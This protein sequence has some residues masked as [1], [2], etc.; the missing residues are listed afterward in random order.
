MPARDPTTGRFM[1]GGG[2]NVG[3]LKV[4]LLGDA[5]SYMTMMQRAEMQA[6]RTAAKLRRL[7]G[8]MEAAGKK[9]IK[10]VT[11]PAAI[12]GGLSVRAFAKF[13]Q[14][15]TESTSIMKVTEKQTKQMRDTALS[16][17]KEA[18]QGPAELARS[19]FYLAS[20]GKNAEQSMALL[21]AMTKFATAGAFDMARATDLL[22]DAQS[23]L[24][25]SSKNAVQDAKNMARVSDV[26]VGANTLANASVEQFAISLTS[27][28]G[29]AFKSYNIQL[30]EGVALLAAYADQGIKAE[31]AGNATDRMIRLLTKAARE[32]AKEFKRLGVRVFDSAGELYSFEKIIGSMEK[33]LSGMSTEL[34]AATLTA[35]GFEARVQ[36]VILPLL[37]TSEALGKYRKELEAMGGITQRVADSQMKS[38]ANRM[39][40]VRNAMS[41]MGISI[42]KELAPA[43]AGLGDILKGIAD[44][45]EKLEPGTRKVII[46]FTAMAA[47]VGPLML[48]M[49]G[50]IKLIVVVTANLVLLKAAGMAFAL[51]FIAVVVRAIYDTNDA[52]V[53]FNK[54]L[55]ESTRLATKL[56]QVWQKRAGKD[57]A[58]AL[59][60]EE[61]GKEFLEKR[62]RVA[63]KE[64][65]RMKERATRMEAP[66]KLK[67]FKL[68]AEPGRGG[69]LGML[70]KGKKLEVSP[71]VSFATL[72]IANAVAAAINQVGKKE[73]DLNTEL[74]KEARRQ[75][76][77]QRGVIAELEDGLKALSVQQK[78]AAKTAKEMGDAQAE[79]ARQAAEA[80]DKAKAAAKKVAEAARLGGIT[81]IIN[82]L[83]G[84]ARDF[85]LG[86]DRLALNEIR[87]MGGTP[88][89]IALAEQA[90][91]ERRIA[92]IQAMKA[93]GKKVPSLGPTPRIRGMGLQ[94][95]EMASRLAEQRE[96]MAGP[97]ELT[98]QE[99]QEEHLKMIRKAVEDLPK[100]LADKILES[101]EAIEPA[102]LQPL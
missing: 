90:I 88:Q 34:K 8:Q 79:A 31:L 14:A 65:V 85:G 87:R 9:M 81:D 23:A 47:A 97:R 70:P 11:L 94:G 42:G 49:G 77:D 60:M 26:L 78:E 39:R 72:G 69:L 55:K 41:R 25:L 84:E 1:A 53:E 86:P 28:A 10:W 16:L 64:M 91:V 100:R 66:G 5:A 3:N 2:G 71:G 75:V 102:D 32:N 54:N 46:A 62:L 95:A 30:E 12:I 15:M 92:E 38:F 61:G 59:G 76:E 40:Q 20:A 18:V 68:G 48:M 101:L 36:A 56:G 80:A 74:A 24:G 13:D 58:E 22:T 27:K 67:E 7:G 6:T 50:L 98:I 99:K 44:W 17:S 19:Y 83:I 57:V 29:A 63:Q 73:I 93:V 89:D 33:A 37:G 96:M 51:V 21:P 52:I 35:L 45:W 4:R 82:R 43:L